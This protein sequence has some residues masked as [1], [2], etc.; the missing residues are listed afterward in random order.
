MGP[1]RFKDKC[2]QICLRDQA[3]CHI[4]WR[5]WPLKIVGG[6]YPV[7][8]DNNEWLI[9]LSGQ[10]IEFV[11]GKG[12]AFTYGRLAAASAKDKHTHAD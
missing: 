2:K 4:Q 1:A 3:T 12:S 6:T 9:D 5:V 7:P 10:V 8:L 11:Q